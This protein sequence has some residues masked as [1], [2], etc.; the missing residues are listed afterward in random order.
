MKKFLIGI[1]FLIPIVVVIALSATGAIISLTTPV[2]PSDMVIKNSSNEE[3]DRNAIIKIDSRDFSEFIIIDVLPAITQDKAITYERIDEA[4]Q[5]EVDL[6]QIGDSN[7][8]SIVPKKIGVTKLEI[9]AKANVNVYKEVTFYVSS[10]SIETMTK[11]RKLVNTERF[12]AS[13]SYMQI[14]THLMQYATMISN[15]HHLIHQLQR[16]HKMVL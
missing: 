8:Y 11:V 5:G 13:S 6:E 14:S 3:I 9:R 15:G 7:R 1:I 12:Q 10:D 2:N 4:G 16:Y